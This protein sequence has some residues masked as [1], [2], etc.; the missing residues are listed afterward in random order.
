MSSIRGWWGRRAAEQAAIKAFGDAV[1]IET[2][3][4]ELYAGERDF[5]HN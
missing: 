4:G 1:I 3:D 2:Q 5:D